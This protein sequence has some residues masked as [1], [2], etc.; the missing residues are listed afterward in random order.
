MLEVTIP[1]TKLFDEATSTFI[2]VKE[3]T[4]QLE[5]SLLAISKWESKWKKAFFA[6]KK[7]PKTHEESIDYIRCMTINRNV[8]PNV[9]YA[10]SN[11]VMQQV[12]LYIE[13]PMTATIITDYSKRVGGQSRKTP[14]VTS[15]LIYYWMIEHGIPFECQ[16]WHLNRLMMLIQICNVRSNPNNKMSKRE[17]MQQNAMLNAARRKKFNSKG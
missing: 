7:V 17:V 2:T 12:S 10:I 5:H 3:T 15:E 14:T 11:Q 4:L 8:D 9:Y 16:K 1:E 6:D 13:D